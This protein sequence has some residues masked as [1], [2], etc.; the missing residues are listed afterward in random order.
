[1][2]SVI[3]KLV[4]RQHIFKDVRVCQFYTTIK[5]AIHIYCFIALSL[6]TRNIPSAFLNAEG[7]QI[8]KEI[9]NC[10]LRQGQRICE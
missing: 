7:I 6:V 5:Q 3:S 9:I 8:N 4:I 10:A 1:M 2:F